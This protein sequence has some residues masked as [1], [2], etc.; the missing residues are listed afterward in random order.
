MATEVRQFTATI[1]AGTAAATPVTVPMRFPARQVTGVEIIVPPGPSGLVGFAL[2]NG[3]TRV[4]P[5]QSDLWII[6]AAEKIEWPLEGFAQTGD[7]SL[8]GYNTGTQD[9][10]VYVRFLCVPVALDGGRHPG[11][12]D[13]SALI[14]QPDF[15]TTG[16]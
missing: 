3:T 2:L 10:A 12:I 7:W 15:T 6:T 14:A 8:I 5:Y 11:I 16:S 1:P 4:I 13:P 9:H